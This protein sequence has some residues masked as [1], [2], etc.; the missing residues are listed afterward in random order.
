MGVVQLVVFFGMQPD[1]Q[2]E[3]ESNR[4]KVQG[5]M[6]CLLMNVL[7]GCFVVDDMYHDGGLRQRGLRGAAPPVQNVLR[8]GFDENIGTQHR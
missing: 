3:K 6:I 2:E 4:E 7:L 1:E 5:D 8:N